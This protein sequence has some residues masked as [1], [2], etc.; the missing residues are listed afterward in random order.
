MDGLKAGGSPSG[1]M[2]SSPTVSETTTISQII[3]ALAL[4]P[5][6]ATDSI[7][8]SDTPSGIRVLFRSIQDALALAGSNTSQVIFAPTALDG[9]VTEDTTGGLL[10]ITIPVTDTLILSE[11]L[12]G[13]CIYATQA[14]SRHKSGRLIIGAYYHYG[15]DQRRNLAL[16][17]RS[18]SRQLHCFPRRVHGD[19]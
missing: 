4:F 2:I 11:V 6:G 1:P 10:L 14:H 18:R 13:A 12:S 16:R 19:Q 5:G 8:I 3:D 17:N 15:A 7:S 9:I